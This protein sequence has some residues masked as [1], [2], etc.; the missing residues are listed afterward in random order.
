SSL[1]NFRAYV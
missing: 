1:E